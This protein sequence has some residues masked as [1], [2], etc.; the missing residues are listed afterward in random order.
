MAAASSVFID[1]HRKR[2]VRRLLI[3][4]LTSVA[5]I[6]ILAYILVPNPPDPSSIDSAQASPTANQHR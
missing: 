6:A 2:M 3:A 1:E 5:F 4:S